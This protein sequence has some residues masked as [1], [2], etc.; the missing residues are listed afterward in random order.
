V[1]QRRLNEGPFDKEEPVKTLFGKE[2]YASGHPLVKD[3]K[4]WGSELKRL[5]T[6][7]MKP[8]TDEQLLLTQPTG[9]NWTGPVSLERLLRDQKRSL[10][11]AKRRAT[12]EGEDDEDP[13][14][15]HM[16]DGDDDDDDADD[17]DDHRRDEGGDGDDDDDDGDDDDDE[18]RSD[19]D[20]GDDDIDDAERFH[21]G[22][23]VQVYWPQYDRMYVGHI[24]NITPC[25]YFVRYDDE[26]EFGQHSKDGSWLIERI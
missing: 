5:I 4:V 6:K 3:A 18:S 26:G 13:H 23:K 10:A 15:T 17:D 14:D 22:D 16:P 19:D 24:S 21:V 20:G 9:A 12:V 7:M 11:V 2:P 1:E 25:F 8:R